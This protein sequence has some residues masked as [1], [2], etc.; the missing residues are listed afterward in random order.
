M[1]YGLSGTKE[2]GDGKLTKDE[3]AEYLRGKGYKAVNSD[4]CV[5]VIVPEISPKAK[6]ELKGII[7]AAGYVG[8]YGWRKSDGIIE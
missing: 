1:P 5:M 4:G 3:F 8:S 2:D 6:K 7:K